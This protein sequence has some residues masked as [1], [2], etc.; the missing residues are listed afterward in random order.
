MK[1]M[2]TPIQRLRELVKI[3]KS[4]D[5]LLNYE[6]PLRR[7]FNIE[8][9]WQPKWKEVFLLMND[10]DAKNTVIYLNDTDV[11]DEELLLIVDDLEKML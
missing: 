10:Y 11:E 2:K 9:L 5:N 4:E 1:L 3:L 6:R 7:G 8:G